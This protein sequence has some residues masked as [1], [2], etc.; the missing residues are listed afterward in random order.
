VCRGKP[1]RVIEGEKRQTG[2]SLGPSNR[3]GI[4]LKAR[5]GGGVVR[6]SFQLVGMRRP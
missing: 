5:E 6:R 3:L 1:T 4:S 2:G